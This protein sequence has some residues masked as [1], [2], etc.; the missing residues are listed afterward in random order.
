MFLT[1]LLLKLFFPSWNFFNRFD[2]YFELEFFYED[3]WQRL[4]FFSSPKPFHFLF[5]PQ[6]NFELFM[7]SQVD[8]FVEGVSAKPRNP[9]MEDV[10]R[11]SSYKLLQAYI[12]AV[13]STQSKGAAEAEKK[14]SFPLRVFQVRQATD[15]ALVIEIS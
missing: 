9:R 10:E 5:N 13:V 11:L 4:E 1:Q 8:L 6:G 3:S 7:R 12:G 14:T 2:S 15:K